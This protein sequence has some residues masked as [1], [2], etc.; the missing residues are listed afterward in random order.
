MSDIAV[1]GPGFVAFLWFGLYTIVFAL[2]TVGIALARRGWRGPA[3]AACLSLAAALLI[4]L[5]DEGMIRVP[6]ETLRWLDR[7]GWA[8]GAMMALVWWRAAARVSRASPPGTGSAGGAAPPRHT[9][10]PG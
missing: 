4:L 3:A 10:P 2:A 9:H 6:M 8:W 5:E 1:F 7:W